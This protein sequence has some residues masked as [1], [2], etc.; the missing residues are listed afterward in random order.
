MGKANTGK[1]T[2][3]RMLVRQLRDIN[4]YKKPYGTRRWLTAKQLAFADPIKEMIREMFPE[5]PKKY[6]YGS[7]KFRNEIIPGAFKEGLPLT[8]RQLLMDLGTE[9][10]RRYKPDIW[11]DNFD[12]RFN[13]WKHRN[14]VIVTD[15][16]FR[17]EFDHLRKNGFYMIRLYRNTGQSEIQHISETGQESVADEEF[18]Y[19]LL[20]NKH[21]K[22]IKL[23]VLQNI[24]PKLI[25][26]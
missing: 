2:L 16:R 21:L 4:Y 5:V 10:G 11:L 14:I 6:L 18:D 24:I 1:N 13:Q 7:S 22:E 23:E 17:N 25:D 3:S 26:N 19:V 9:V 12:Y 8:I 15:V 20:N